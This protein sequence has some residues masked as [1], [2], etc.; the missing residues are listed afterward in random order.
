MLM[1]FGHQGSATKVAV[2]Q[3]VANLKA[4]NADT[5]LRNRP[6][7]QAVACALV[8]SETLEGRCVIGARGG[9]SLTASG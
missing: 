3:P 6:V 7:L 8:F 5:R 4:A 1:P 9:L 2:D